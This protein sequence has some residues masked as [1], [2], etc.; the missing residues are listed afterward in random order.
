[1]ERGVWPRGKPGARP[2]R[3]TS[4]RA[5]SERLRPASIVTCVNFVH[6]HDV[7]NALRSAPPGSD[8]SGGAGGSRSGNGGGGYSSGSRGDRIGRFGRGDGG[9]SS[10]FGDGGGNSIGGIAGVAGA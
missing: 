10:G 5:G 2:R 9:G 1:M 3:L 7:G 8:G 6:A 4:M